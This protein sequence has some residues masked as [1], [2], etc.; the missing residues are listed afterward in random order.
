MT[1]EEAKQALVVASSKR[2]L[3]FEMWPSN[4]TTIA[5]AG[6]FDDHTY[7]REWQK[8][9]DLIETILNQFPEL[10]S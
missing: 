6:H 4:P 8:Y 2:D 3:A 5:V 10:K 7:A 9:N 1:L